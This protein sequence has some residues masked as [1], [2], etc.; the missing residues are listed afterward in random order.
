MGTSWTLVDS[1]FSS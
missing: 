1:L